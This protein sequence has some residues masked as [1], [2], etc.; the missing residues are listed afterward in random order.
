ME[1]AEAGEGSLVLHHYHAGNNFAAAPVERLLGG[2]SPRGIY[3]GQPSAKGRNFPWPHGQSA[4]A[5]P[6][7]LEAQAD[8]KH[9]LHSHCSGN[10]PG[11]SL[12]RDS[13]YSDVQPLFPDQKPGYDAACL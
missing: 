13:G 3:G 1:K 9:F 7:L 2:A 10:V 8:D 12:S 4:G 5:A 11:Y 6:S